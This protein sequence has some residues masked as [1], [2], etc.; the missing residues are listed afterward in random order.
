MTALENFI[1]GSQTI[2]TIQEAIKW[3][4]CDDDNIELD[5]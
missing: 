3:N 5:N 1:S 2:K 4:L